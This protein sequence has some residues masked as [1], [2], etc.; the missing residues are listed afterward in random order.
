[1]RL[2]SPYLPGFF[3]LVGLWLLWN[4]FDALGIGSLEWEAAN[5]LL[6]VRRRW[7]SW[8]R[9]QRFT[10]LKLEIYEEPDSESHLLTLFASR[11]E[12]G[13]ELIRMNHPTADERRE[14]DELVRRLARVTGW[15]L[16]NSVR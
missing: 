7:Y 12:E 6:V 16:T 9:A 13:V 3:V 1:M 15:K 5:D 4:S 14:M 2:L 11:G 10:R 8:S